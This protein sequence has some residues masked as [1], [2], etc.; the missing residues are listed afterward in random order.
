MGVVTGE[1]LRAASRAPAEVMGRVPG[2][3]V[4][5]AGGEG[6]T[7]AIR[8]PETTKPMYLFL[9]DGVPTRSTGFFN[10]NALYEVNVPQAERIEVLKGPGTALYGSDAIGGVINVETRA[11]LARARTAEASLEGGALRL[12]ARCSSAGSDSRGDDGVRADLNLTRTRRL[13][14]RHRRTTARAARC[15][16]TATSRGGAS[17]QDGR[18][19]LRAST[20][21]RPAPPS[22]APRTTSATRRST[23][24]RSPSASVRA[25]RLSSA[26]RARGRR[27]AR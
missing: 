21:R 20:S 11:R 3:W 25:F 1:E 13:A 10:H 14:R 12:D 7:T 8:Q 6:H 26:V 15:A 24:R 19:L 17:L 22:L 2:V 9:E 18:D 5:A 4:S 16:G 27:H 23:T